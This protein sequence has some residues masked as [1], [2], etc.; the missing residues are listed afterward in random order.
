MALLKKNHSGQE[1]WLSDE[2]TVPY[3]FDK[4]TSFP[5]FVSLMFPR[6]LI[7]W[8]SVALS[9]ALTLLLP[10]LLVI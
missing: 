6:L 1:L 10:F 4:K 9:V 7:M 8:R 3:T 5:K 2:T